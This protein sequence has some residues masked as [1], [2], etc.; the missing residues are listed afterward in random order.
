MGIKKAELAIEGGETLQVMFN[1]AS[2]N[3]SFAASYSEKR[4]IGLDGPI[5]Q[6]IAGDSETLEMT[7]YFDTYQPPT[8]AN[9][10][11]GGTDVTRITRKL[12]ALV[13]IKGSLH[14]PPKVTFRWG[15]IHFSG[16]IVS[17]RQAY[18]MFL[19]DGMPVR[20]RVDLTFKS[21]LDVKQSRHQSPFES[22]D[23]TKLR[24]VHEGDQLWNYAWE[25]YG[26]MEQWRLIAKENGIMN[27]LDITPGQKIRIPALQD[28]I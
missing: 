20:A 6:Y 4:V 16:V 1:P 26:D 19:P 5:G 3:L 9:P 25:E 23:R 27:P 13:Q 2:Y 10:A 17:V 14:R 8:V 11:E 24:T 18:T 7:L 12:A 22:P 15:G 21:I 28:E